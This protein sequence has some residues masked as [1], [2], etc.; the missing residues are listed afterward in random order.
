MFEEAAND[1][2]SVVCSKP[3]LPTIRLGAV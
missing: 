1:G 3:A 2:A